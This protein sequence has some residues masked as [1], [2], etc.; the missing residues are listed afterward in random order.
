MTTPR[1][2]FSPIFCFVTV[3]QVDKHHAIEPRL[4]MTYSSRNSKSFVCWT[5]L[6]SPLG[7]RIFVSG[8]AH[9]ISIAKRTNWRIIIG[10]VGTSRRPWQRVARRWRSAFGCYFKS[11][12][13][14]GIWSNETWFLEWALERS[15]NQETWANSCE[16]SIS[17]GDI[18]ALLFAHITIQIV[19][20]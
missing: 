7:S 3:Q 6:V 11:I 10:C 15:V 18:L 12:K 20:T 5:F 16:A 4:M 9:K 8:K 17:G 1:D 14:D 13:A 2:F 19:N